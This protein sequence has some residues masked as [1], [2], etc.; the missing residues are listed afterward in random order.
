M[1]PPLKALRCFYVATRSN[2]FSTAADTLCITPSAVSHNIKLL[3]EFLGRPLFVRTQRNMQL[4]QAGQAYAQQIGAVFERIEEATKSFID[5]PRHERLVVQVPASLAIAWLVPRLAG[6]VR[7]HPS[8]QIQIL[9]VN[10]PGE[11]QSDCEIRFGHGKWPNA[12]V[13]EL[14]TEKLCP[15]VSPSGPAV[16]SLSDLTRV[17]LIHTRSRAHGWKDLFGKY[18]MP[19]DNAESGLHFDRTTLALEAASAG[20]GIALE[21]PL[22]ARRLIS[23]GKLRPCFEDIGIDDEAYF[24]VVGQGFVTEGASVFR[25]W[26]FDQLKTPVSA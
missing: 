6:F 24:F 21:S 15:L 12:L 17:P 20:L 5:A 13:D 3:E 1:L 26:L 4:T 22:I 18:Q 14:W 10:A 8:I 23:E 16:A 19:F 9:T 11:Q 7:Q 25:S 2:N